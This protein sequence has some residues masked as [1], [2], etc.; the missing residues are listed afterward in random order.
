MQPF[1][2]SL[3]SAKIASWKYR[4]TEGNKQ[5]LSYY[6]RI[7]RAIFIRAGSRKTLRLHHQL[8]DITG[9]HMIEK[10]AVF[11]SPSYLHHSRSNDYNF[12]VPNSRIDTERTSNAFK[13]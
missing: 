13:G 9:T 11:G 6:H 12:I 5:V 3:T 4:K 2:V 8:D 1:L 10:F 7:T